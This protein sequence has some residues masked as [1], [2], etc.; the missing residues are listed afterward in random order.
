MTL[1]IR[2]RNG[3]F[4]L[5]SYDIRTPM[6]PLPESLMAVE[7]NSVRQNLCSP[8]VIE[9]NPTEIKSLL[10]EIVEQIEVAEQTGA[11]H[12]RVPYIIP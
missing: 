10:R 12:V 1:N 6:N 2:G 4:K 7:L 9:G 5:R 8:V 11:H 3:W